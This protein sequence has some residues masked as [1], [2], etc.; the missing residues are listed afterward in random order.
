[1][2]SVL[3]ASVPQ[4]GVDVGDV[5]VGSREGRMTLGEHGA[6]RVCWRMRGCK[7]NWLRPLF[8]MSK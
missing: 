8:D 5:G 4:L 3:L 6:G 1:M 2:L 7:S